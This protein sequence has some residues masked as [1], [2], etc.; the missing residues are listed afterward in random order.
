MA[1]GHWDGLP[2]ATA[3]PEQCGQHGEA[4]PS[5]PAQGLGAEPS[6]KGD[7]EQQPVKSLLPPTESKYMMQHVLRHPCDFCHGFY[8]RQ[9]WLLNF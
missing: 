7:S 1:P 6:S 3:R 5:L 2:M 8:M 9:L 4:L